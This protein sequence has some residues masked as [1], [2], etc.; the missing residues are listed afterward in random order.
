MRFDSVTCS[1]IT[2]D[3]LVT[4]TVKRADL[5]PLDELKFEL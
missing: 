4:T 2:V 5:G 1:H 3:V